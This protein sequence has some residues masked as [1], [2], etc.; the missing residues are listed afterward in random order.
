MTSSNT[1]IA[2]KS[3]ILMSNSIKEVTNYGKIVTIQS[4]CYPKIK[5]GVPEIAFLIAS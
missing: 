2:I 4:T 3:N 1:S 5:S